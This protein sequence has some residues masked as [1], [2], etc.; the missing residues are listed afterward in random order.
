MNIFGFPDD[1]VVTQTYAQHVARGD[2]QSDGGGAV[3]WAKLRS[4]PRDPQHPD[5]YGDPIISV[6]PDSDVGAFDDNTGLGHG[7]IEAKQYNGH[8]YERYLCHLSS[9]FVA[10]GEWAHN[11]KLGTVIARV[12]NST[13]QT[14][15]D[16]TPKVWVTHCHNY[17][18][19]DGVTLDTD[20][21][22]PGYEEITA[23][24]KFF[25]VEAVAKSQP[26][27]TPAVQNQKPTDSATQPQEP[28]KQTS[29]DVPQ[30][31]STQSQDSNT[32]LPIISSDMQTTVTSLLA[33]EKSHSFVI[34]I[35]VLWFIAEAATS[36][37]TI[38]PILVLAGSW[39]YTVFMIKNLISKDS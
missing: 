17:W 12:G 37:I 39:A 4:S 36:H 38:D 9:Q 33:N 34:T 21:G 15:P 30:A 3:D 19:R 1:Y 26:T 5:G 14:Y 22:T 27:V 24:L 29:Q 10:P 6:M 11:V 13:G 20:E 23:M 18:R 32:N 2:V 28:V 8:H 7:V 25:A 16:G 31:N 35:L